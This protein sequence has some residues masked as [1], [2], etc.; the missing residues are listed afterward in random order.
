MD[1]IQKALKPIENIVKSSS[2]TLSEHPVVN[3]FI[4]FTT[5]VVVVCAAGDL[6]YN[7]KEI[8]CNPMVRILIMYMYLYSLTKDVRYSILG[9]LIIHIVFVLFVYSMEHLEI[10]MDTP[11]I[12]PGCKDIKPQD[13]INLFGNEEKAKKEISLMN[14][15]NGIP[16]NDTNAP[17]IAT[18]LIN[19]GKMKVSDSCSLNPATI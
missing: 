7:V 19:N 4:Y 16:I 1:A 2:S 18:Y 12:Y 17:V 8:L 14:I 6:P 11:E 9:A 5:I 10:L 15:P 3:M 13:I